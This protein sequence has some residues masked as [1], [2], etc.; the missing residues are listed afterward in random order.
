VFLLIL[1]IASILL[2]ALV[3]TY[4]YK[5]MQ[6]SVPRFLFVVLSSIDF[7]T[8]L[9]VGTFI[10]VQVLKKGDPLCEM[11]LVEKSCREAHKMPIKLYGCVDFLLS[12][13]PGFV[14]A[15]MSICRYRQ[16]RRPFRTISLKLVGWCIVLYCFVVFIVLVCSMT[17]EPDYF[18]FSYHTFTPWFNEEAFG[19]GDEGQSDARKR[20]IIFSYLLVTWPT[21]PGQLV[22]IVA[23]ALTVKHLLSNHQ[24]ESYKRGSNPKIT[25]HVQ[26]DKRSSTKIILTNSGGII[27][28]V[29]LFALCE[30]ILELENL[31]TASMISGFVMGVLPVFLSVLN[32]VIFIIFTPKLR[33]SCNRRFKDSLNRGQ[34]PVAVRTV[35]VLRE[36]EC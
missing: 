13:T 18:Y 14:A 33:E 5:K 23:S 20:L 7:T 17:I 35:S 6:R 19:L 24:H 36:S 28:T 32:P 31:S 15:T 11:V 34:Y 21:F 27:Q 1:T 3:F 8:G 25:A 22:S 29:Y 26:A 9:I 2:N 10:T 12:Q 4:N 30:V 16:L